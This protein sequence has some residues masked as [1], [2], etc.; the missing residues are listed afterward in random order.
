MLVSRSS[1]MLQNLRKWVKMV[2][3][4]L[5]RAVSMTVMMMGVSTKF[6]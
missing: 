2:A 5:M 4:M 3:E 1:L 6:G